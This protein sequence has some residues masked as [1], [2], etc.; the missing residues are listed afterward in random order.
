[1]AG[2]EE[3]IGGGVMGSGPGSA[4]VDPTSDVVDGL[5]GQSFVG[6][7]GDFVVSPTDRLNEQAF[8]GLARYEG[9]PM[10]AAS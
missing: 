1:M 6:R 2:G 9:G 8:V 5:G 3:G 10:V 4:L 7:H